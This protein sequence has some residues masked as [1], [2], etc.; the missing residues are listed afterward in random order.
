MNIKEKSRSH[1]RQNSNSQHKP[2]VFSEKRV[3]VRAVSPQGVI[4]DH[5]V[6]LHKSELKQPV[7]HRRQSQTW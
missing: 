5:E 4:G 6:V 7:R 1:K 2:D 3:N